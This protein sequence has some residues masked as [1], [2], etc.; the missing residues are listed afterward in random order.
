[1][2]RI[3]ISGA[4]GDLGRRITRELLETTDPASL[5]LV[6]RTPAG[7][8]QP[9]PAGVQT[10]SADFRQPETLEAAYRHCDTLMLISGTDVTERVAQH[11]AAL[12]AARQAGVRHVVYTSVTGIHPAN[13]SLA[14]GDHGVT[15]QDLRESGLGYTLL[16]NAAYSEVFLG[17]AIQPVLRSGKWAQVR[18]DGRIAPVSKQDIARCAATVLGEPAAHDGAN[19]EISGP[20]LLT[21]REI[22]AEVAT[23][24]QCSIDYVECTREERLAFWDAMG[25]PRIHSHQ[26]R[27]N[28]EIYGWSGQEMVSAEMAVALGFHAILSDHV[29]FITGRKP[30]SLREVLRQALPTAPPTH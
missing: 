18:G 9:L 15:E 7:T 11:R 13:P 16:R 1:M 27:K 4:S 10:R 17:A 2:P 19:Y 8:V 3:A 21:T 25:V 14:S 6:T 29:E 23:A 26:S 20:E 22:A 28:P 12:Q 24:Y 30:L 5:V